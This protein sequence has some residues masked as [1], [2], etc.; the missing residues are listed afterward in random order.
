MENIS[1][2]LHYAYCE[3]ILKTDQQ[4]LM[5]EKIKILI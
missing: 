4:E 5:I 1:V 2:V 3:R